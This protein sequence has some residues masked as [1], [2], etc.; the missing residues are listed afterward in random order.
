LVHAPSAESLPASRHRYQLPTECEVMLREYQAFVDSSMTPASSSLVAA[1]AAGA[2]KSTSTAQKPREDKGKAKDK[3]TLQCGHYKSKKKACPNRHRQERPCKMAHDDEDAALEKA[4]PVGAAAAASATVA[5]KD[6]TQK[7]WAPARG[8]GVE[9][10]RVCADFVV[11]CSCRD[12]SDYVH[13]AAGPGH[14]RGHY[15][16][17]GMGG[18][19]GGMAGVAG[20]VDGRSVGSVGLFF[21]KGRPLQC[22]A[23]VVHGLRKKEEWNGWLSCV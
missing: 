20:V 4:Q 7:V 11:W 16:Y 14:G 18:R 1:L 15:S 12:D 8:H 9:N 21:V 17:T 5:A 3:K 10:R 19:E 22:N 23:V 13:L 2:A 6:P